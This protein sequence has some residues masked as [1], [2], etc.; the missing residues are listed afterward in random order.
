MKIKRG[1]GLNIVPFI[2]IMLVLLAIVLSVSTFIAQ[3]KIKVDV[4]NASDSKVV[5]EHDKK[6]LIV[7]N[8]DNQIYI[9]DKKVSTK[10]L[11]DK[12]TSIP[13]DEMVQ[14]KGDKNS[15]Y[16]NFVLV[17]NILAK[18]GHDKDKFEIIT[19]KR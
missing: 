9:D 8:K 18:K 16:D 6:L 19:E 2:D 17:L 4:P 7:I 1:D 11:E 5:K 14:F 3:G 12:L 10:E 13:K 15:S